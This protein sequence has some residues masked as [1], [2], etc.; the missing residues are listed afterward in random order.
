[1]GALKGG[2]WVAQKR[3]SSSGSEV[4][5]GAQHHVA[6]DL[7]APHRVGNADRRGF[8]NFRAL[9]QHAVDLD[10]RNVDAAADD[11]FLFPTGEVEKSI[12]IEISE[13]AGAHAAAAVHP[14]RAIVAEIAVFV[15]VPGAELDMADLAGRQRASIRIDDGEPVIGERP[16]DAAEPPLAAGIGGDPGGLAA[17][18]A[19]RDGNAEALLEAPPFFGSNGA[20]L[21]VMK[22]SVGTSCGPTGARCEQ[23]VDHGGIAGGDG[24]A[25]DAHIV[26]EA[27]RGELLRHHQSGAAAKRRQHAEELRG[28]P[29][30]GAEIV[31]AVGAGDAEAFGHRLDVAELLAIAEHHALR[32]VAGP[33]GEEDDAVVARRRRREKS[34]PPAHPATAAN[35]VPAPAHRSGRSEGSASPAGRSSRPM[36]SSWITSRGLQLR[37]DA[38]EMP[39]FISTWTVQM[40]APYAITPI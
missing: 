37:H 13:V 19:L 16:A 40:A 35:N 18:I 30:E 2:N 33:G 11:Q 15:V 7:L 31:N 1:M 29:V 34:S 3:R 4:R 36:P 9:H 22:R 26:E 38:S 32:A 20:E 10:R 23:H 12:G 28:R 27:G 6:H 17:A 25:V 8:G 14:H 39:R 24:D 5:A 21:E